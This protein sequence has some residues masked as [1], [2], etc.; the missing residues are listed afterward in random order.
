MDHLFSPQP[1]FHHHHHHYATIYYTR[2]SLSCLAIHVLQGKISTLYIA[3]GLI[4]PFIYQRFYSTP[5]TS[6]FVKIVEVGPRDGLQNE[7]Q[8][9]PTPVKVELIQRLAN[10][11]LPVVEA[12]SFVSPKWVPQMGDHNEVLTTIEKK[13]G[14]SYPV[15]TPNVRGVE[16]ALKAGA[17]EVAMFAAV[18]ESFNKKNTNCSTKEALER[19]RQVTQAALDKGLKVRG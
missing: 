18:T 4:H 17:E 16:N 13:A 6:E 3:L 11:G 9:I 2:S 7:K 15:L 19:V 8:V 1:L 12:T 5:A 10:A 14:V